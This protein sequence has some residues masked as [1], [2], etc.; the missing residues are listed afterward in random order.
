MQYFN[1]SNLIRKYSKTLTAK[2]P[3]TGEYNNLGDYVK[4]EP[5][6]IT[7]VGAIISHRENKVFRSAGT[8]TQQDKALY[9][10]EP[11]SFDLQGALVVEEGKTYRVESKLE[12]AAFTGV[13][14]YTL[15]YQ[16]AFNTTE[17]EVVA[18]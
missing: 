12:N 17:N 3:A 2:L 10:L 15:K 11:L 13:F 14:A 5:T 9:M 8:L 6:K 16:S 4:S 1:F 7:F 18:E